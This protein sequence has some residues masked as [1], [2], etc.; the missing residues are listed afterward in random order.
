MAQR[1]GAADRRG[2]RSGSVWA[3]LVLWSSALLRRNKTFLTSH[4]QAGPPGH[5]RACRRS[6]RHRRSWQGRLPAQP[7]RPQVL[8]EPWGPRA[9]CRQCH[10][11][12][13]TVSVSQ[14]QCCGAAGRR[15]SAAC[16]CA[17]PPLGCSA[18]ARR[19]EEA[20]PLR[21]PL[22]VRSACHQQP[23][24]HCRE[25]EAGCDGI[26][27]AAAGLMAMSAPPHCAAKVWR[28]PPVVAPTLQA[29]T[30]GTVGTTGRHSRHRRRSKHSSS[31]HQGRAALDA[32]QLLSHMEGA[33]HQLVGEG[34]LAQQAAGQRAAVQRK[35]NVQRRLAWHTDLHSRHSAQV[36][37]VCMQGSASARGRRRWH[38]LCKASGCRMA[39]LRS[40]SAVTATCAAQRGHTAYVL[41][42]MHQPLCKR[43]QRGGVVGVWLCHVGGQKKALGAAVQL[44][45]LC[46]GG[47]GGCLGWQGKRTGVRAERR[48]ERQATRGGQAGQEGQL[49]ENVPSMFR[50]ARTAHLKRTLL[51]CVQRLQGCMH[52]PEART[53]C[54]VARPSRT[55]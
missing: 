18:A 33:A 19:P 16:R 29:G 23:A 9:P 12:A 6:G 14:V 15:T 44:E 50:S 10:P 34:G 51:C 38:H 20:G 8:P 31:H 17:L 35:E 25:D 28:T 52:Y 7:G 43:K 48:A 4:P 55:T 2:T 21:L 22:A 5:L 49:L 41:R 53:P 42:H 3:P 27:D 36:P 37:R 54:W 47:R 13:L 45:H 40:S 30:A 26:G 46:R 39:A 11:L 1:T 24:S 32:S